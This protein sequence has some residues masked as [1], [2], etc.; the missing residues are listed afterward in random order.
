MP[1]FSEDVPAFDVTGAPADPVEL[2]VAW[3]D[4][5]VQAG[6]LAPHAP[7]LSTSDASQDVSARTIALKDVDSSGWWFATHATSPKGRA[8]AENA[9]AALT[10]FWPVVG[11]Q[12]RVTGR[13]EILGRDEVELDFLA[14]RPAARAA[15]LVGHQS[16]PLSSTVDHARALATAR[17]RIDEDPGLV[18][19]EW[20]VYVL[21]AD[22]VEFWSASHDRAHTRLLYTRSARARDA[23]EDDLWTQETLWP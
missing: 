1:V 5:A 11:R 8:L 3:L 10:F 19:P 12:V 18:D 17:A 23:R 16:E 2:F 21:V 13:V 9:S 7:V 4:A 14:R 22:R 15:T 6:Q 20:A